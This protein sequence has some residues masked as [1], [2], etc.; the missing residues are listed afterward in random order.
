MH[1]EEQ[2]GSGIYLREVKGHHNEAVNER[3]RNADGNENI[4]EIARLF[5]FEKEKRKKRKQR[6]GN[7]KK[8]VG[9]RSEER[10]R[11]LFVREQNEQKDKQ[12]Y[13]RKA[14]GYVSKSM[15]LRIGPA[16]FSYVAINGQKREKR[17]KGKQQIAYAAKAD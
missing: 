8:P 17:R 3:D 9:R 11:V 14:G 12:R 10:R 6:T 15:R 1:A 2:V 4:F 7:I 16:T 5:F 13:C